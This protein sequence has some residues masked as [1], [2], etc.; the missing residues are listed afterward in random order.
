MEQFK[1]CGMTESAPRLGPALF[2]SVLDP[3]ENHSAAALQTMLKAARNHLGMDVAFVSNLKDGRRYFDFVDAGQNAQVTLTPGDSDPAE[4]SYCQKVVDGELPEL[5]HDA[6]KLHATRK[7]PG[8]H[9]LPVG[10]HMSVPITLDNGEI[11]GTF[12]CFSHRPEPG[13]TNRDMEILRTFADIASLHISRKEAER[14]K[15]EELV[16]EI[17]RILREDRLHIALQPIIDLRSREVVGL[18]ALS[19]FDTPARKP[20]NIWFEEAQQGGMEEKLELHAIKK[21]MATAEEIPG[22]IYISVN[23]SPETILETDKDDLLNCLH[24]ARTIVEVT[25]HSSIEDYDLIAEALR[26]LRDRG[27]RLAVDDAGAGYASFRHILSLE[28]DIIKLDMS[29]TRDIDTDYRKQALAKSIIAF[30]EA[31]GS[32]IVAEGIET[33]AEL[34]EL[35]MLGVH[36]GQ[37]YLTGKPMTVGDLKSGGYI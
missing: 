26:P 27:A 31:T 1:W 21:A 19:R 8:T 11:Y 10:S 16:S 32:E 20:P 3:A 37:G 18:E 14:S 9:T 35:R 7:L 24:P 25:E 30:A 13:V 33:G 2:K 4:T 12:C 29:I 23:L 36:K 17:E 5:I 34:R 28:P 15:K 22:E 6:R